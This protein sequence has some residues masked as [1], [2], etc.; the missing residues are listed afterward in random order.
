MLLPT[1]LYIEASEDSRL[2]RCIS[3]TLKKNSF[4]PARS[5][6]HY[7]RYFERSCRYLVQTHFHCSYRYYTKHWDFMH[8][9]DTDI[10][11]R[12]NI[13]SNSCSCIGDYEFHL[14][15]SILCIRLIT[16]A[17]TTSCVSSTPVERIAQGTNNKHVSCLEVFHACYANKFNGYLQHCK[18]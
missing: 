7:I 10:G 2:H 14:F 9:S 17:H 8:R 12:A 18:I 1:G 4:K 13:V 11:Y 15:N 3:K 6:E 5:V 16:Q